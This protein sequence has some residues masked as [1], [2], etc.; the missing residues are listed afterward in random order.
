MTNPRT[1]SGASRLRALGPLAAASV[2]VALLIVLRRLLL[3]PESATGWWIASGTL[4]VL[5]AFPLGVGT[6]RFAAARPAVVRAFGLPGTGAA[7]RVLALYLLAASSGVVV[8]PLLDF[9]F[10]TTMGQYVAVAVLVFGAT[11]PL[12]P[13]DRAAARRSDLVALG[14]LAVYWIEWMHDR[15]LWLLQGEIPWAAWFAILGVASLLGGVLGLALLGGTGARVLGDVLRRLGEV[16]APAPVAPASTWVLH[17]GAAAS[18][19]LLAAGLGRLWADVVAPADLWSPER[20]SP[21]LLGVDWYFVSAADAV[22]AAH[23]GV[24]V[25]LGLA[26]CAAVAAHAAAAT[27]ANRPETGP[28]GRGEPVGPSVTGPT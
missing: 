13:P 17:T 14:V 22:R 1:S 26:G 11:R 2:S 28:D 3:G 15:E 23:L 16:P 9:H 19:G 7:A 4:A 24:G 6:V 21:V 12:R 5:G 18:V 8:E 20:D 27:S 10:V 25:A